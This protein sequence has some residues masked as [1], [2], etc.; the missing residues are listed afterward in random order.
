MSATF[1]FDLI[2]APGPA[3]QQI[4]CIEIQQRTA[5]V[6]TYTRYSNR[7]VAQG[8]TA[9]TVDTAAI[10]Q[11]YSRYSRYSRGTARDTAA[12]QHRY[13][14]YSTDTATLSRHTSIL[15]IQCQIQYG[16][17]ADTARYSSDTVYR[18]GSGLAGVPEPR[19][20]PRRGLLRVEREPMID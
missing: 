15:E 18:R 3:I 16:H 9:D 10:Q 13:S 8:D 1:S 6:Y 12:I 17:S 5:R 2:R 4:Q 20:E 19:V 7:G 14:R 11:R